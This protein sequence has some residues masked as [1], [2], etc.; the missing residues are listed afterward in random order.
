MIQELARSL[1]GFFIAAQPETGNSSYFCGSNCKKMSKKNAVTDFLEDP[2]SIAGQF[3][4]VEDFYLSNQKIVLGVVGAIV[5]LIAGFFGYRYYQSSQNEA[6]QN[7]LFPAVYRFE[8]DSLQTALN[9]RASQPGLV[10]VGDNYGGTAAGNLAHFYAGVAL[11]KDGK[12][13]KAIDELKS[14][15][16]SDLMVQARAYA[17]IGDAYMEKKEFGEA[18]SYYSKAADYKTNK[19]F[20]PTYLMKLALAYEQ[21]KENGKALSTYNDILEKYADAAEAPSAKKYKSTLEAMVGE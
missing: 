10:A 7:E 4:R 9:G 13:D 20:T 19:Y 15:S 1:P 21:A 5:L 12:Y 14:F 16:S 18:A 11:L 17:L 8:G 3:D 6:G 2:E